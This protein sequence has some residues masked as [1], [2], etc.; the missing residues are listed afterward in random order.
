MFNKKLLEE[1]EQLK[2][3]IFTLVN[4]EERFKLMTERS[5]DFIYQIN[6]KGTLVYCSPVLKSYGYTEEEILG[7]HFEVFILPI[8]LFKAKD[9]HVSL[10]SG[11]KSELKY[12]L[13]ILKKDGSFTT[14]EIISIPI[15]NKDGNI[16]GTQGICRDI[17][18]RKIVE[19]ELIDR[20]K[21]LEK[22][23]QELE[24]FYDMATLRELK[25]KELK[26]EVSRL[27]NKI[28][29]I[30]MLSFKDIKNT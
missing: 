26:E 1:I 6:L 23:V 16:D 12:E 18:D 8:D 28:N 24:E 4:T 9:A 25:I 10:C 20:E 15:L 2:Q 11:S 7:K 22:R 5:P 14:V 30:E 19:R 17:T 27:A 29:T 3:K 13:R 21:E